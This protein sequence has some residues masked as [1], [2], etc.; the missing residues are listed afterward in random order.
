VTLFESVAREI[1]GCISR[2]RPIAEEEIS[3]DSPIV[4]E[5]NVA[6]DDVSD[7]AYRVHKKFAIDERAGDYSSVV[8]VR[9]WVNLIVSEVEKRA[10]R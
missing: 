4:D 10:A 2:H 7:I 3:L 6:G 9:D 8:T 5:L 1:I